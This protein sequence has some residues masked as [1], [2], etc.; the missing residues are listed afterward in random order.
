MALCRS[1]S[2]LRF[3]CYPHAPPTES[4][5]ATGSNLARVRRQA[6][7]RPTPN[8][9]S[10]HCRRGKRHRT[11]SCIWK[12]PTTCRKRTYAFTGPMRRGASTARLAPSI[13]AA[14]AERRCTF[15]RICAPWDRTSLPQRR[16]TLCFGKPSSISLAFTKP[17]MP[18]GYRTRPTSPTSCISLATTRATCASISAATGASCAIARTS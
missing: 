11:E 18:W 3:F 9:R 5:C 12:R 14:C 10:G 13:S 15:C 4:I 6:A 17:A 16:R 1:S 7:R 8:W 2:G